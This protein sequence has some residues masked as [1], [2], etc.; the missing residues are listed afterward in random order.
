METLNP[1]L[2]ARNFHIP[3]SS[4]QFQ[5]P[6]SKLRHLKHKIKLDK[7]S[8]RRA[9]SRS[10]LEQ[11]F[12]LVYESYRKKGFVPE[13]KDHG[14]FFSL[15]SLLP[16]TIH[17]MIRVHQEIVSN[18]SAV[19]SSKCFGLPM[20]AIYKDELDQLRSQGRKVVEL[21]ALATSGKHRRQN[22][23]LYQIQALYWY[24]IYQGVDDICVTV[25]PRH[26]DYYMHMF[27]F[28]EIGPVRHY[29]RVN[30]PA[31][32]LRARVYESLECM[33]RIGNDL[34]LD[35]P[36][37]RYLYELAGETSR[38]KKEICLGSGGMQLVL[39]RNGVNSEALRYF[40]NLD[41]DILQGLSRAQLDIL[42]K[43]SPGLSYGV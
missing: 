43:F 5:A 15:Y 28:E 22:I 40:L 9:A 10:E 34:D 21:S 1:S 6:D 27:P 3:Q 12:S 17:V 41:P 14:M 31:V 26:K 13:K 16:G 4:R 35:R 19:P 18:L 39:M 29:D 8:F 37:Y 25:N 11:A 32:G 42:E 36:F 33:I 20:D 23:F 38:I 7:L 2:G 30:A 24:F